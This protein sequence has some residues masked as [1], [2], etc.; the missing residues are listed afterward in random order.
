MAYKGMIYIGSK[1]KVTLSTNSRNSDPALLFAGVGSREAEVTEG[2]VVVPG[3]SETLTLHCK[4]K[5]FVRIEV[6]F[7]AESD[8]GKL[9][10]ERGTLKGQEKAITGDVVWRYAV[11]D[12]PK[13]AEGAP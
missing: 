6:D 3:M 7:S 10:V 11:V 9:L 13:T 12:P 2:V 4:K 8:S 1:V 5:G